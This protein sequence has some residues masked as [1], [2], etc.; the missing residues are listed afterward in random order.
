MPVRV[1]VVRCL[2]KVT[3]FLILTVLTP[4]FLLRSLLPNT[5]FAASVYLAFAFPSSLLAFSSKIVGSSLPQ[6]I[7]RN[8]R[9]VT[10]L[11]HIY[12][13]ALNGSCVSRFRAKSLSHLT[14]RLIAIT[15]RFIIICS[16]F[17]YKLKTLFSSLWI[18]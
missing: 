1:K 9:A 18:F 8:S 12:I 2:I 3:H 10:N 16:L 6:S 14:I 15:K 13:D 4:S 17:I 7:G 11:T 5:C